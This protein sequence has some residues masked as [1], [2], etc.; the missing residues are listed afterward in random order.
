[1]QKKTTQ[2]VTAKYKP[3]FSVIMGLMV[4]LLV[5]ASLPSWA[6][7][8]AHIMPTPWTTQ[9]E[10]DITKKLPSEELK[11]YTTDEDETFSALYLPYMSAEKRGIAILIPDWH[12]S[13]TS[14]NNFS[15]LRESLTDDGFDTFALV[16]PEINWQADILGDAL[17]DATATTTT[18][19][20]EVSDERETVKDL[21]SE[22]VIDDYKKRLFARFTKLYESLTMRPDEQLVVI[23][24]G[25]S[26]GV[27][28]EQFAK[29]P[30]L[31]VNAFVAVSAMLP[32]S[33]RNKHL[34]ATLS[35]VGPALLDL[36][37]STDTPIVTNAMI[38]RHRWARRNAKY[39]YRQ[40]ELYGLSH[41]PS[42]HAR[43]RKEVDGF[44]RQ[45]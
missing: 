8:P 27:L 13:P 32:N 40:R 16:V 7:S 12:Q 19:T 20:S 38:D 37:Y 33:K 44:L 21:V 15:Y 26:A 43:L 29:I 35:L 39:D 18:T 24:Q 23:A 36:Y 3:S 10:Q 31:R 45:L 11:S 5:A 41:E 1:M 2:V 4:T 17:S 42:Q 14:I 6:E 22:A 30:S 34:P 28:A 25:T 9:L